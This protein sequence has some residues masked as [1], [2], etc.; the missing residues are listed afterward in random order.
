MKDGS[1]PRPIPP[2][3]S[4]AD[5]LE[6]LEIRLQY[7][8]ND[9]ELTR[10]EYE[11]AA[12]GY[13]DALRSVE[14][15]KIELQELNAT[16]ETRVQ[17][18]TRLLEDSVA[19]LRESESRAIDLAKKADVA[20]VA[21]GEFLANMS[22][23]IRTPMNGVIGMLDMLLHSDLPPA[24]RRFA[25][26]ARSSS[27]SLL[28][29]LN[30]VLDYSKIE[31]GKLELEIQEF[32]LL[33]CLR[34]LS[35]SLAPQA[36]AKGLQFLCRIPPD[37]PEIVRG[38]PFRLR[39]ILSNLA[40]NA[41][42]FTEKGRVEIAVES[43]S[44]PT[45]SA[46]FRFSVV[47][48]G[49]GIP[50]EKQAHLFEKFFQGDASITRRF[51]GTGLG[52]PICK[53]LVHLMGGTIG[54]TSQPG[55]GSTFWFVVPL[56]GACA[57]GDSPAPRPAQVPDPESRI[58]PFENRPARI[59]LADDDATNREVANAL[60][61]LLGLRADMV[62]NGREAVDAV[63]SAPY[64]LV[65]LD[66]QMPVMDGLEAARQIRQ[67]ERIACGGTP[68]ARIPIVAMTAHAMRGDRDVCLAAGMDDYLAK[69]L[70]LKTLSRMLDL[71]LP[72]KPAAE[73]APPPPCDEEF[74]DAPP[75]Q[76]PLVFDRIGMLDRL[77]NHLPLAQVLT[78]GYLK[79]LPG[80]LEALRAHLATG[81]LAAIRIHSH[82][83]KGA[84]AAVGGEALAA[85]LR[86][87]ETEAGNSRLDAARNRLPDVER[88]IALLLPAIRQAFTDSA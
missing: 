40:G 48:T 53:Q 51:G 68:H 69:P 83:M 31:A 13:L 25:E 3:L 65:L 37:V 20:N 45:S 79:H 17:D 33:R 16:L 2:A 81:D 9:L 66:V 56:V 78:S 55:A 71:W 80:E 49:L 64:D 26:V 47:D 39:Q 7:L 63:A 44:A 32:N 58:K 22:H 42:K 28:A 76:A 43:V 34:D 62:L 52:L 35:D 24:Q 14:R 1:S 75:P 73:I 19:R 74:P 5:A 12:S 18:R 21:K 82:K 87:M 46:A 15:Q 86:V 61:G 41:I 60:L 30:D 72:R 27:L 57:S 36:S 70:E 8:Q 23:E 50:P 54:A 4:Q 59:L 38:D 6:T 84:A 29:I 67:K 88:E 11:I 10:R 85:V 77:G